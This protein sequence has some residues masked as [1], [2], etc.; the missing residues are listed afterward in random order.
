MQFARLFARELKVAMLA[1]VVAGAACGGLRRWC[2][3]GVHCRRG[4]RRYRQAVPRWFDR[5]HNGFTG[6]H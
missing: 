3:L 1:V 4:L 5:L 6:L 2:V